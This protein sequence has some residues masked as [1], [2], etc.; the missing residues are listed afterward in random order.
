MESVN[1]DME[2]VNKDMETLENPSND[3]SISQLD[4][5]KKFFV[6]NMAFNLTAEQVKA[7]FT[8]RHFPY[9]IGYILLYD[10]Y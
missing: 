2:S 8:V 1:K 7:W 9:S 4:E 6:A 5:E 3:N 10:R